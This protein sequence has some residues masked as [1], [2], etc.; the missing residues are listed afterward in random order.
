ML[1]ISLA[2]QAALLIT[3]CFSF[4]ILGLTQVI[5]KERS[6][7]KI[8]GLSFFVPFFLCLFV[9]FNQS[10]I[11]PATMLLYIDLSLLGIIFLVVVFWY[12]KRS[13][14]ICV[15]LIMIFS[16]TVILTSSYAKALPSL[17][18]LYHVQG[19]I[20]GLLTISIILML[21]KYT[22]QNDPRFVGG[23]LLLGTAQIMNLVI[24][25]EMIFIGLAVKFLAYL[26]LTYYVINTMQS[27]LMKRLTKAESKL[28]DLDK[29]INIEVKKKMIPI[30]Q[31]NE[32]LQNMVMIDNLTNAYTKK[33]ILDTIE[34]RIE[35]P[36]K[37]GFTVIMFD[38]DN[39]KILNDTQGH[40][41]GDVILKKIATIA[42][43]SIRNL[44]ILGRY[45]GDEFIIVLPGINA[46]EAIFVAERFRKK[47]READLNISVSV[48]VASYPEDGKTREELIQI[49]D[50]GLYHSKKLGRD[51]VTYYSQMFSTSSSIK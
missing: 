46:S 19:I 45:G 26:L 20:V 43:A 12:S 22:E 5:N 10:I 42:R 47:V 1:S 16:V 35:A 8:I 41:A 27:S 14:V 48:G 18:L 4:L 38:V 49:A 50:A 33:F 21:K 11:V 32:H 24:T 9:V 3:I 28:L 6:I 36:S 2:E 17:F 25:Q 31:H 29:T 15:M 37:E 7:L 51:T 13:Y 39:F 30:V 34:K 23:I 40:L 44:D